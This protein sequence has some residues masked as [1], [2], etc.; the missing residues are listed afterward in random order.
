MNVD[1]ETSAGPIA[2]GLPARRVIELREDGEA[3]LT[4]TTRIHRTPR[5]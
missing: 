1:V 2:P 4:V 5:W 3:G